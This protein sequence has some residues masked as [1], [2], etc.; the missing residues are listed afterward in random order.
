MGKPHGLDDGS[1]TSALN[2]FFICSLMTSLLAREAPYIGTEIGHEPS[3]RGISTL[4]AT[5]SSQPP[6]PKA[7]AFF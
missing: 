3:F 1:M 6:T 5:L 2:H 4:L 7:V